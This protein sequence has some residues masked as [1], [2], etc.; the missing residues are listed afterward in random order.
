MLTIE[1]IE[2]TGLAWGDNGGVVHLDARIRE[3]ALR[4]RRSGIDGLVRSHPGLYFWIH[5]AI[6]DWL[7]CGISFWEEQRV[8]RCMQG[9]GIRI[10][11]DFLA[12]I[13]NFSPTDFT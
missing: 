8:S 5:D 12:L 10:G 13:E 9:L 6:H 1:E 4:F 3:G 11:E 2:T 7:D